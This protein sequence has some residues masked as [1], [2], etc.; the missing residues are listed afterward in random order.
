MFQ[1]NYNKTD[2]VLMCVFDGHIDTNQCLSYGPE[3]QTMIDKIRASE[4]SGEF[5]IIF[6]LKEV[7]YI[8]SSFIRICV[9]T[10][11]QLPQDRFR[12]VNSNPYIKKTFKVVGLDELLKMN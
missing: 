7:S 10:A 8:A 4:L 11:K 6:D 1:S 9:N 2:K 12:I 5:D 3:L